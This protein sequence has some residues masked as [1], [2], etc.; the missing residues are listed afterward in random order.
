M[1][2]ID[3]NRIAALPA[4]SNFSRLLNITPIENIFDLAPHIEQ[5]V[6]D[7]FLQDLIHYELDCIAGNQDYA[8]REGTYNYLNLF[9]SERFSFSLIYKNIVDA[10]MFKYYSNYPSNQI[11]CPLNP[12]GFYYNLFRRSTNEP[13]DTLRKESRLQIQ[14]EQELLKFGQSLCIKS[15]EQVFSFCPGKAEPVIAFVL[16]AT[17]LKNYTWE[18][19]RE[20][21]APV[22]IVSGNNNHTRV[23]FTCHI[24]GEIGNEQSL[25]V[26]FGLLNNPAHNVRWQAARSICK[27]DLEQGVNALKM[28]QQD[29]H[30]EVR[31]LAI[32][33][34]AK[35]DSLNMLNH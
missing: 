23:E 3:A 21:L 13:F 34:L 5:M 14:S 18:Y 27:L 30:E 11:I 24:L 4:L 6:R 16:S 31:A 25:T 32:R 26:L 33:S 7:N 28:L 19:D 15:E 22:R 12:D 17:D 35:I 2:E 20:T 29:S 10:S 9:I 8:P 1:K